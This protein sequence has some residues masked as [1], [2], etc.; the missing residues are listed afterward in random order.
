M[1]ERDKK[2]GKS[3]GNTKTKRF[4]ERDYL[5]DIYKPSKGHGGKIVHSVV[6]N[7]TIK[8]YKRRFY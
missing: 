5:Q 2:Q 3:Y 1:Q 6:D 8:G 7:F 4:W